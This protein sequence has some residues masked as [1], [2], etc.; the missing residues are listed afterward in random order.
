MKPPVPPSQLYK[1]LTEE[2]ST[3]GNPIPPPLILPLHMQNGFGSC[4][5]EY[6]FFGR[7]IVSS[8]SIRSYEPY[9][10]HTIYRTV[11]HPDPWF[12]SIVWRGKETFFYSP[13]Q[14]QM[15]PRSGGVY[16]VFSCTDG[17][18]LIF[19]PRECIRE[20]TEKILELELPASAHPHLPRTH[21][22]LEYKPQ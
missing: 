15:T 6:P 18:W 22:C 17:Q 1:L 19:V 7:G 11:V 9:N 5:Q 2:F 8:E 3:P 21:Q 13:I 14:T 4:L 20:L 10:G 16:F 12:A